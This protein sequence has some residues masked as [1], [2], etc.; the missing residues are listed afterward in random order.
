M[1]MMVVLVV[2]LTKI[3]L[4][5]SLVRMIRN[6]I[7][8]FCRKFWLILFP[9]GKT[10]PPFIPVS[11]NTIQGTSSNS[12]PPLIFAP[13]PLL[14]HLL[15]HTFLIL[16]WIIN[17]IQPLDNSIIPKLRHN[18]SSN[19]I[20]WSILLVFPI[21]LCLTKIS[22]LLLSILLFSSFNFN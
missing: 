12:F 19:H 9:L 1:I 17:S 18:L 11:I 7:I 21:F 14:H 5:F 22:C 4:D 6:H 2:T 10:K 13:P 16:L 20:S 15:L 3:I 8:L